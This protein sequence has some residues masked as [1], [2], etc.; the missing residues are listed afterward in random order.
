MVCR[1]A[2]PVSQKVAGQEVGVCVVG[3]GDGKNS[4]MS[5]RCADDREV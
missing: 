5:L 1:K 2:D 4:G 3:M